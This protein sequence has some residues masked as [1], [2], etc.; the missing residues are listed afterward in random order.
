MQYARRLS[1]LG[2]LGALAACPAPRPT[3]SAAPKA[4]QTAPSSAP[5]RA[6]LGVDSLLAR[7]D[8]ISQ[9][10]VSGRGLALRTPLQKQGITQE[11]VRARLLVDFDKE[12]KPGE[13]ESEALV[14]KRLRLIPADTD[15]KKLLIDLLTEQI[16]GFYDP[17]DKTLY[18]VEGVMPEEGALAHEIQHAL[19]DQH[20]DLEALHERGKVLGGD[21]SLAISALIEGDAMAVMFDYIL[22]WRV[23]FA[24]L[25]DFPARV[26]E[27][28]TTPGT[29]GVG[30]TQLDRAPLI[31]REGLLFPYMDGLAFLYALRQTGAWEVADRAFTDP[32]TSTEQILHPSRY[33]M[34]DEPSQVPI[35]A[36]PSLAA[37]VR[38]Y[39]SVMGEMQWRVF[40]AQALSPEAAATAAAGWDGDRLQ[41][42]GPAEAATNP[43]PSASE[44]ESLAVAVVSVWDTEADAMEAQDAFTAVAKAHLAGAKPL[45]DG[46]LVASSG[47]AQA[48]VL[49]Q[50]KIVLYAEGS[51]AQLKALRSD[52]LAATKQVIER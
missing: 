20:F 42:F 26:R 3:T 46:R 51:E 10:I 17:D 39:E 32:P 47:A 2:L 22:R 28:L 16:A 41:A 18:L 7:T 29:A 34:R 43:S 44:I 33:L 5:V 27:Q 52:L 9:E 21:A 48:L 23:S 6:P 24:S 36:A 35:F 1:C 15:Y 14:Y 38:L 4:A 8:A 13:L 25:P 30:A 37:S 49:R 12:L 19:Q 50:Q 11:E 40:F 45:S 31:V